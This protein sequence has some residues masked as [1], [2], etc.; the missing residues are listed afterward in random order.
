MEGINLRR[1]TTKKSFLSLPWI[2]ASLGYLIRG[3]K[4]RLER[5]CINKK[6]MIYLVNSGKISDEKQLLK[7]V[8]HNFF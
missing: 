3:Y 1:K 6:V 4:I 8:I 5:E 7:S 2:P